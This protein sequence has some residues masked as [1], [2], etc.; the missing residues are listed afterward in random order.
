MNLRQL[1][2][3]HA[4]MMTGTT[5]AAAEHLNVSQPAVSNMIKHIEVNLDIELF[6]R[7][8][9][10]LA[11]TEEASI[12]FNEV[13][14]L[15]MF[16]RAID[17]KITDIREK[18]TGTLRV[19]STLSPASELVPMAITRF[20]SRYPGVQ[21]SFDVQRVEDVI[22][23]VLH[24]VADIGVT[25]TI[26]ENPSIISTP[27]HEGELLCI[28]PKG[29]P[30]S[31]LETISPSDLT[32]HPFV[33]MARGTPLGNAIAKTFDAADEPMKWIVETSFFSNACALVNAGVGCALVDEYGARAANYPNI[34]VRLFRPS[35]PVSIYAVRSDDRRA[36]QLTKVFMQELTA[37]ISK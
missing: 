5:S 10:R 32:K 18:R 4:V 13:K 31:E 15:F 6:E 11:P 35:I 1:E 12:L 3:F 33:M 37:S 7:K 14:P 20:V 17:Q 23:Q 22:D 28:A 30:L 9:G 26:P 36:S 21:I 27:I 24:N 34:E 19:V 16:Y 29:H 8:N 25:L 2:I